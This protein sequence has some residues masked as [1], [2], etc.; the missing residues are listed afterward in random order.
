M[1]KGYFRSYEI[2]QRSSQENGSFVAPFTGRHGWYWRNLGDKP[3][4]IVLEAHGYYSKLARIG[5]AA[6]L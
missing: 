6:S 1:A 4:T 3:I 5:N 2:G